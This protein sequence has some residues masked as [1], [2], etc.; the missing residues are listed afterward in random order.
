M[1]RTSKL[2]QVLCAAFAAAFFSNCTA[3]EQPEPLSRDELLSAMRA[4]GLVLVMRHAHS[5]LGQSDAKG[6]TPGCVLGAGRGL[7][8]LGMNQ[9]GLWTVFIAAENIPVMKAY[10]SDRCRAWDTAVALA[11][12]EKTVPHPS[13]T[14]TEDDVVAAFKEAVSAELAAN[15]DVNIALVSHSNVAPV[16][17]AAICDDE[18]ELPEAVMSVVS[19][20]SWDTI[21]RLAP[22]GSLASC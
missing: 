10:T 13:Q 9:A 2:L 11:G 16:Y 12:A 3:A 18:G 8:A 17:G 5:P 7:D 21:G 19:P 1:I 14:S 6:R 20:Q 15:P 4:G 22:D